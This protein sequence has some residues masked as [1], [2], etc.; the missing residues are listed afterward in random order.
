MKTMIEEIKRSKKQKIFVYSEFLTAEGIGVFAK[1]L[2]Y[3]GYKPFQSNSSEKTNKPNKK[4]KSFVIWSGETD[5]KERQEILSTFNSKGNLRGKKIKIMLATSAGAEGLNLQEIRKVLVM[6][7]FWNMTRIDQVVGRASR[8]CSHARLKLEERT[9]QAYIY[10][11]VP[12]PG[13]SPMIELNEED[14]LSTDKHVY[15]KAKRNGALLNQF[16]DSLK[17]IAIDCQLNYQ[18]NMKTLKNECK[19]CIPTNEEMFPINIKQHLIPGNTKCMSEQSIDIKEVK[20][21]GKTYGYDPIEDK[22]YDIQ[23]VPAT[24][25][26]YKLQKKI[27]DIYNKKDKKDELE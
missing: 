21:L 5:Y 14:N 8:L 1:A 23:S 22:A 25:L 18:R 3:N 2:Q 16:R 12:P 24:A 10:L 4:Y 11:S 27:R 19:T 17:E 13:I 15:V 7:P 9:A 6:E 26:P 20:Y